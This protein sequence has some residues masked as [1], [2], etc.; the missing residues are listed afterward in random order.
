M[1]SITICPRAADEHMGLASNA[2]ESNDVVYDDVKGRLGR[3]KMRQLE[4]F[5][6]HPPSFIHASPEKTPGMSGYFA[7]EHVRL[8]S[9]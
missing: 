1:A 3:I 4:Y 8:T 2:P 5:H 6:S 7:V 9:S